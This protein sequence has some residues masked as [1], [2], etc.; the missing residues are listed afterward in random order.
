MPTNPFE[1]LLKRL[2][3]QI[4]DMSLAQ[5]GKPLLEGK[6]LSMLRTAFN[7]FPEHPQDKF[8]QQFN[9]KSLLNPKK[10]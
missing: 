10:F 6:V 7:P 2:A 1:D 4:A 9:I 3:A 8:A 5:S